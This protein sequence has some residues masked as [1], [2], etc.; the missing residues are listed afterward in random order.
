MQ[1]KLN[2]GT[3]FRSALVASTTF[4]LIAG[5]VGLLIIRDQ[6]HRRS[7]AESIQ[8]MTHADTKCQWHPPRMNVW[9]PPPRGRLFHKWWQWYSG[10]SCNDLTTTQFFHLTSGTILNPE[11]P[12]G[13]SPEPPEIVL[14]DDREALPGSG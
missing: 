7:C 4:G 14:L 1:C 12:N 2:A 8:E 3:T 10:P 6:E 11:F 5:N 13:S 9:R